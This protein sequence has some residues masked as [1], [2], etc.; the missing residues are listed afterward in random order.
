MVER[1][2]ASPVTPWVYVHNLNTF[3]IE[4]NCVELDGITSMSV[5][6]PLFLDANTIQ[7]DWYYPETGI[8]RLLY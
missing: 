8:V 1:T 5:G 7:I 6:A 2:F 3:A 4:V